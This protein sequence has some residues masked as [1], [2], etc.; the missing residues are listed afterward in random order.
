VKNPFIHNL[1]KQMIEMIQED[2]IYQFNQV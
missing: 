2:R 1:G